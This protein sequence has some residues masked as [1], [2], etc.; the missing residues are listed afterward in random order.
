MQN[1]DLAPDDKERFR[2]GVIRLFEGTRHG[3]A[4]AERVG[5]AR[6]L[7]VGREPRDGLLRD[8]PRGSTRRGRGGGPFARREGG[9]LGGR[10]GRAVRAR[11]LQRVGRRR[12]RAQ[13]AAVRRDDRA[14]HRVVPPLVRRQL[15][16]LRR[17]RG[18]LPVDQHMLLALI[19]PRAVYVASADE[20]LWADPRGE[21]LS[22]VARVPGLRALG[23]S[24]DRP[25]TCRR[26]TGRSSPAGAGTTSARRAQPDAV[27]LGS[28]RRLRGRAVEE[29]ALN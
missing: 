2:E 23:R 29:T 24:G 12:R 18:A 17:A 22:L 7:G 21:F 13:P 27:R 4:A 8:R 14:D 11:D 28:L 9:A 20:D 15:Q 26:S 5:R 19:A 3:P 10:R 1:T 16:G 6:G 25:T